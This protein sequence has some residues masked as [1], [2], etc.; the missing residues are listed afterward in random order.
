MRRVDPASMPAQRPVVKL[1]LAGRGLKRRV[2]GQVV[3]AGAAFLPGG[4]VVIE[5]QYKRKGH[6]VTLHKRSKNANRPVRLLAASA[7]ARPL[8][9]DRP[10]Q[11]RPAVHGGAV[12]AR[13]LQRPLSRRRSRGAA[14]VASPPRCA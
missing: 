4:K 12:P 8:A 7:Q 5:W 11:G 10:L 13:Q 2:R 14:S 1:K 3:A 9:R 6:W